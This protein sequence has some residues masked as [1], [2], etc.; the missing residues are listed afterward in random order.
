MKLG[1]VTGD[2]RGLRYK[3]AG[4]SLCAEVMSPLRAREAGCCDPAATVET[5]TMWAKVSATSPRSWVL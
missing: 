4:G 2:H 5:V 1:V 3:P